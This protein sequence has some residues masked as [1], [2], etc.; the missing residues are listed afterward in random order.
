MVY[1]RPCLQH[2]GHH[3]SLTESL[4]SVTSPEIFLPFES[5]TFLPSL[6][7][8][9]VS[10]QKRLSGLPYLPPRGVVASLYS[11]MHPYCAM[12][13]FSFVSFRN[14]FFTKNNGG[15]DTVKMLPESHYCDPAT[16]SK[17]PFWPSTI[18]HFL[19][20]TWENST[21]DYNTLVPLRLELFPL[22]TSHIE[23][24]SSRRHRLNRP[25]TQRLTLYWIKQW[26]AQPL[27]ELE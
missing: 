17:H 22:L 13:E 5:H 25:H 1:S 21:V 2:A 9:Q 6:E 18:R 20:K 26:K 14:T 24:C 7:S 16:A 19:D 10:C 3:I 12:Y 15:A 8:A 27:K 11:A 4:H 23:T